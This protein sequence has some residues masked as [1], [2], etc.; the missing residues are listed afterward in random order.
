MQEI[1]TFKLVGNDAKAYFELDADVCVNE[2]DVV[3]VTLYHD[4][5]A[6]TYQ[7]GSEGE[8]VANIPPVEDGYEGVVALLI[9]LG[10]LEAAQ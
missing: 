8:N 9:E 1:E 2:G 4:K 3:V 6:A 7:I 5:K 10:Y